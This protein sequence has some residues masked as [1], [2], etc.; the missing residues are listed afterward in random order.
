MNHKMRSKLWIYLASMIFFL[1]LLSFIAFSIVVF[2]LVYLNIWNQ[3]ENFLFV[4]IFMTLFSVVISTGVSALVGRKILEPITEL[5]KG[6]NKVAKGDLSVQMD[7]GPRV[8]EVKE[9]FEDFN[10]MVKE[11]GSIETFRN[12]FVSSV[13]HEFKTPIA[14]IRGYVQLL[15]TADLSETE[16]TEFYQRILEGTQQLST[17]T[18]NVLQLTKLE[19]QTMD[20]EKKFFRID[21][22]IREV[23]LFLQPKWEKAE[24]DLDIELVTVDYF[25]KEE[26]LYQVWLNIFDNAIKYSTV[27]GTITVSLKESSQNITI[28]IVDQGIGLETEEVERV[29][30]KFYQAD[31]SRKTQ[32]NG[33]GLSLCQ[34]IIDLHQGTIRVNSKKN[35]GTVVVIQLPISEQYSH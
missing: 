24:L 30:D 5:R 16:K 22:Q 1:V 8:D 31:T 18:D 20:M 6:M 33:L 7:E 29:F 4:L 15:Q 14:I 2:I 27:G 11:L 34:K 21:E 23:I 12:D 13:S 19:N 3:K 10:I 28:E 32:G 9:L 17:L 35:V 25:G 26:L